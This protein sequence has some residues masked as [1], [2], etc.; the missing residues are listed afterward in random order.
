MSSGCPVC[1]FD[2]RQV[3]PSDAATALRSFP[4][5]FSAVLAGPDDEDRPDDVLHRRPAGGGLSALEHAGWVAAGIPR[6][7]EAFAAVMYQEDPAIALPALDPSVAVGADE[8]APAAVV[9]AIKVAGDALAGAIEQ[10][11]KDGWNRTG[12]VGADRVTAL[13]VVRFAVHLGVHHLRLAERTIDT[14]LHELP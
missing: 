13:D 7:A 11:P 1:G 3:S 4:R 6:A 12:H 10:A 2:G 9:A 14:V 8:L 5:R